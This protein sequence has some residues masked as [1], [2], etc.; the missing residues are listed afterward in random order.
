M[1]ISYASLSNWTPQCEFVAHSYPA[2]RDIGTKCV[3][4]L[5]IEILFG[6]TGKIILVLWH[7]SLYFHPRHARLISCNYQISQ[8]GSSCTSATGIPAVPARVNRG[9]LIAVRRRTVPV[10]LAASA[11]SWGQ[12]LACARILPNGRAWAWTPPNTASAETL[13]EA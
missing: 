6:S 3:G 4:Y 2:L 8:S 10:T 13:E 9:L 7:N 12:D 11:Y 1:I 5:S